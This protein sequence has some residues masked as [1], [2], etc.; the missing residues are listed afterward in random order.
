[1]FNIFKKKSKTE[2]LLEKYNALMKQAFDLSKIN[3]LQSD[4]KTA[5]AQQ[6]L[7][8]IESVEKSA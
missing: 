6:L 7:K 4:I 5:E 8:Q 2:I 3:R 1:M